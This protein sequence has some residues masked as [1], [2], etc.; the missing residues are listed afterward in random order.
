MKFIIL[1][2]EEVTMKICGTI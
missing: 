2:V 1:E